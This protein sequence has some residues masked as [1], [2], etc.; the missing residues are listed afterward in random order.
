MLI[1]IYLTDVYSVYEHGLIA[2]YLSFVSPLS[3]IATGRY[4]IAIVK[5]KDEIE[6]K[7]LFVLST[8]ILLLFSLLIL[9]IIFFFQPL[10]AHQLGDV[11]IAKYLMLAPISVFMN[12]WFEILS[13]YFNRM[14]A[15]KD[16]STP[17]VLQS[18]L[19]GGAQSTGNHLSWN[20]MILGNVIG[21]AA[22]MAYMSYRWLKQINLKEFTQELQRKTLKSILKAYKAYPIVNGMHVLSDSLRETFAAIFITRFYDEKLGLYAIT[23]KLLKTPLMFI[24]SAIGKVFFKNSTEYLTQRN[25]YAKTLDLSK[26]LF[27]IGLPL[28]GGIYFFAAD[29]FEWIYGEVWKESGTYAQMLTL[30]FFLNFIC[31]PLS[32]LTFVLEKQ[33]FFFYLNLIKST[34]YLSVFYVAGQQQMSFFNALVILNIVMSA[35]NAVNLFYFLYFAKKSDRQ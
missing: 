2:L 32:V 4:E 30:L 9:I 27:L 26:K 22:T 35:L 6:A 21:R 1:Y 7:R 12:G 34:A 10:I 11:N 17:R 16:M 19:I 8:V 3:V 29:V 31:S 13:N 18:L 20:G 33:T 28:F 15:Y 24:S 14:K 25:L 23:L 5:A